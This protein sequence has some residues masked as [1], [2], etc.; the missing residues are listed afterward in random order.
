MVARLPRETEDRVVSLWERGLRN[1]RLIA[2]DV[3]CSRSA[4]RR[5]LARNGIEMAADGTYPH[6]VAMRKT[7]P[8]QDAEIVRRYVAGESASTLAVAFGF[9]GPHSV[10]QRVRKAGQS[11]AA[12][13][14]RNRDLTP[15]QVSEVLRLRDL[16]WTQE[17]IAAEVR[18]SQPKVSACLI[19]NGRRAHLVQCAA[20]VLMGNGYYSVRARDGDPIMAAMVN[21]S[22]Y[23]PEHRYI[24]AKALGR[25]LSADE[26]VHHINGDKLDNRLENLQLRQGRH[27][28]GARFTCLECG[29]HNVKATPLS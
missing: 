1:T 27:G 28:K 26:T 6:Y 8:E 24:M 19:A 23:V 29:S 12:R 3:G 9:R 15:E 11:V 4:V 13:G 5:I 14:N 22:R 2:E 25:A 17:A 21:R 7:T 20:R 10:L 16:G 18:T